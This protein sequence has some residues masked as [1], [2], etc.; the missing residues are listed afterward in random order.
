MKRREFL[1]YTTA[2]GLGLLGSGLFRH[3]PAHAETTSPMLRPSDANTPRNPLLVPG[4][5]GIMGVL[6]ATSAPLTL[7]AKQI[8]LPII[9]GTPSPM[10]L[11][12]TRYDGRDFT[13]PILRVKK[14][15]EFN[16]L[17]QND[18]KEPHIVH[19]HG[20]HVPAEMDGQPRSTLD[21]GGRFDYA[22]KV[23]N[24]AGL[25]WYHTH[26]HHRTA[27]QAY[28]GLAGLYI[29]DDEEDAALRA[30]LKLE[31]GVNEIPLVIQDRQFTT[32]GELIYDTNPM[33]LHMG[34]LGDTMLVNFTPHAQFD[35]GNRLYRFRI[36]NGSNSRI[37]K[38]AFVHNGKML[39]YTVIGTD[40]GL[41]ERPHTAHEEY[42]SPA[43]RI[44]ILFDASTLRKGDEVMLRSLAF[45]PLEGSSMAD[46]GAMMGGMTGMGGMGGATLD[47]GAAFDIMK[48][49]VTEQKSVQPVAIPAQLS[50]IKRIDTR[51]VT[52]RIVA[53]T[54]KHMHWLING[55]SFDMDR[56]PL[57]SRRNTI[58]V[59]DIQNAEMSMPHP[60][61]MHGFSFQVIE[62]RNSPA[63]VR[64]LAI[65]ASGRQITDLGWKDTVQVWPAET[66][67]IS[68]DFT[69]PYPGDQL[70][71][72]HC[73]NLE[74]EDQGMMVN[75]LVTEV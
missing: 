72:F 60:M 66:V 13:N 34:Q 75:H 10:M 30:A 7:T 23:T 3:D 9:G 53:I 32:A 39:P 48:L 17:L 74:H 63:H 14:G 62:R 16:T 38:L 26:A 55:E 58:E 12:T 73:H 59:W 22:F 37:Y 57:K 2:T 27:R 35:I 43:E 5:S 61:H 11:Y 71:L 54:V 20:L 56:F 1:Q 64:K 15:S 31:H 50:T 24:R 45:N 52:P 70:Y 65:D 42:L 4:N 6:D 67:R 51:G 36:L 19:W 47:L 33:Q 18:L 41:L 49:V 69:H 28:F 21:P 46:M 29:V 25:Y 8:P 40:T 44:D 68:I